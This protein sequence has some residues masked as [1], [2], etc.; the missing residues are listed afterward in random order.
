MT[1]SRFLP[2]RAAAAVR[3]LRASMDGTVLVPMDPA[4]DAARRVWNAAVDRRPAVIARCENEEDVAAAVQAARTQDL[5]LSV[6]GGGLDWAGRAMREDGL[7]VDL[8]AMRG[9]I[10]DVENCIAHAQG[11]ATAGDI[12][13]AAH[14]YGLAPVTGTAA[15]SGMAGL[16]LAGGYGPL[17]GKHGLALDNLLKAEV[18][19][20]DGRRV[21]ASDS[22]NR[23][24]FWALRGAGGSFGVVASATYRLHSVVSVLAG[25][26]LFPLREAAAVLR[27]YHE[28]AAEAPDELTMTA[29]FVAGPDGQALLFLFPCWSGDP[30]WGELIMARLQKLGTP[31]V[32]PQIGAMTYA[33][34]F[35]LPDSSHAS[36]GRHGAM[37]SCWLPEL[38][39]ETVEIL[40]DAARRWTSPFSSIVLRQFHGAA[41]RVPAKATAFA[42]RREHLLV[43]ILAAWEPASAEDDK[44]HR[45]WAESLCQAL[46]PHALPGGHPGLLSGNE[47]KRASLGFGVNLFRLRALKQRYDPDGLLSSAPGG[48]ELRR[49]A[50]PAPAR[51]ARRPKADLPEGAVLLAS[52][53]HS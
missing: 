31:V 52:L 25:L 1:E 43:E 44:G 50:K 26:M 7:V 33:D 45:A 17:A 5:P 3:Q 2:R 16:T 32:L 47:Q 48:L 20:A 38:E 15:A 49:D 12:V 19:L 51:P 11:G 8:S 28:L 24:L 29:G 39:G 41:T 22:E 40:I 13:A 4:Y 9:V 21:T 37:S 18:I 42:L 27:G 30:F 23:E 34:A 14:R 36:A 6:R 46:L 10:V 53:R 35:G